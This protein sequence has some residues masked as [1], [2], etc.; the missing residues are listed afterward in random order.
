MNDCHEKSPVIYD[1]L[2]FAVRLSLR[3]LVDFQGLGIVNEAISGTVVVAYHLITNQLRQDLLGNLLAVFHAPL[4][5]AVNIPNDAL[6]KNLML[7]Q[8]NQ[9][10]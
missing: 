10:S 3:S 8:G 6:D 9:F 1:Q 5:I 2:G 4:V 7:I